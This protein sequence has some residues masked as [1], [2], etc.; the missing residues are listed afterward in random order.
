MIMII[1]VISNISSLKFQHTY[2]HQFRFL[3]LFDIFIL[4]MH[5]ST[6]LRLCL[7]ANKLSS[8]IIYVKLYIN[9]FLCVQ[10][11]SPCHQNNVTMIRMLVFYQNHKMYLMSFYIEIASILYQLCFFPSSYVYIF[12]IK[13][14]KIYR[15]LEICSMCFAA[16]IFQDT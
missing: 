16:N 6:M 1:T 4:C 5:V 12:Q 14:V 3:F 15:I 8:F 13:I 7:Y 11:K 2:V 9:L 10:H